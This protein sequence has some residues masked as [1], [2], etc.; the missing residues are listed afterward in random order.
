MMLETKAGLLSILLM[1]AGAGVFGFGF[2]AWAAALVVA[3]VILRGLY[4]AFDWLFN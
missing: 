3:V 1:L 4:A 2:L